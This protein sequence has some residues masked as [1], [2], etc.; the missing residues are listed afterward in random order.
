MKVHKKKVAG[1]FEG[2]QKKEKE[3]RLDIIE[4]MMPS[5]KGMF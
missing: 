2:W 4:D 5:L 3:F 1:D